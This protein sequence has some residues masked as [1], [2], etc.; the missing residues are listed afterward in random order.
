[1]FKIEEYKEYLADLLKNRQAYKGSVSTAEL[2]AYCSQWDKTSVEY[3]G[4]A[5]IKIVLKNAFKHINKSNNMQYNFYLLLIYGYKRC[6]ICKNILAL[7]S[8][9]S[10]TTSSSGYRDSCKDCDKAKNTK[11]RLENRAK[12]TALEGSRRASKINATPKWLTKE[13][14]LEIESFYSEADTLSKT[15]N[16]QY[17]VDH[18]IPLQGKNVCG[19]H[20]PWNLRVITLMDN[21]KK[22]NKTND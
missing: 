5:N 20:V 10:S 8:Y 17:S 12:L 1:M 11:Y 9:Y 3:F 2:I 16:I 14:L 19:L 13:Q 18:I 4:Y 21:I 22:G 6:K 7:D 15:T